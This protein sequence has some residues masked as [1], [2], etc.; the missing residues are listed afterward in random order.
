MKLDSFQLVE[1][2]WGEL[3]FARGSFP[4]YYITVNSLKIF[5][6]PENANNFPD[7]VYLVPTQCAHKDV[8]HVCEIK[9]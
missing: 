5:S 3:M 2:F 8:T 9:S 4:I 1:R 7:A 6:N